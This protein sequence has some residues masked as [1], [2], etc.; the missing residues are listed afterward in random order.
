V[1]APVLI[2]IAGLLIGAIG[3]LRFLPPRAD[4]PIALLAV[5]VAS[6]LLGMALAL[7]GVDIYETI[8]N[9]NRVTGQL[10]GVSRADVLLPAAWSRCCAMSDRSSDL[11]PSSTCR[12]PV[13]GMGTSG[14]SNADRRLDA[15]VVRRRRHVTAYR[16]RRSLG[17]TAAWGPCCAEGEVHVRRGLA[18]RAAEH[19]WIRSRTR[20]GGQLAGARI[21]ADGEAG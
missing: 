20:S 10:G 9:I 13:T 18:G 7:V 5:G 2:F 3:G 8:R 11:R 16:P 4:R 12:P 1:L 21:G 17:R 6:G 15:N 14:L 19:G